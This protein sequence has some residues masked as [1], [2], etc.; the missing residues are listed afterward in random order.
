MISLVISL[1]SD[2]LHTLKDKFAPFLEWGL[3]NAPKPHTF[4]NSPLQSSGNP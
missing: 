3:E 2:Y 4:T 1:F